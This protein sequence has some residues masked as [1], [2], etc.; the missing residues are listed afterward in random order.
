M[1]VKCICWFMFSW[2]KMSGYCYNG[3]MLKEPMKLNKKVRYTL[4]SYLIFVQ[5]RYCLCWFLVL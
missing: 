5:M 3:L 4:H 2:M 1:I